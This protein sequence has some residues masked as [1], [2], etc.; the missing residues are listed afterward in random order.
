VKLYL[1][2]KLIKSNTLTSLQGWLSSHQGF[3]VLPS[4]RAHEKL[5]ISISKRDGFKYEDYS[6]MYAN[7]YFRVGESL[8][9]GQKGVNLEITGWDIQKNWPAIKN[10]LVSIKGIGEE[11]WILLMDEKNHKYWEFT[12]WREVMRGPNEINS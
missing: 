1:I 4:A 10:F 5:G 12:S 7:G 9:P 11:H 8:I 6:S 2:A 3:E